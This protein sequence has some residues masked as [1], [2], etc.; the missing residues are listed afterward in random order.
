MKSVL[1]LSAC[2]QI[3][4]IILNFVFNFV[5]KRKVYVHVFNYISSIII[6]IILCCLLYLSLKNAYLKSALIVAICTLIVSICNTIYQNISVN[7]DTGVIVA[8]NLLT[9]MS[10]VAYFIM[11]S[12]YPRGSGYSDNSDNL[13]YSDYSGNSG[14]MSNSN[15]ISIIDNSTEMG[16]LNLDDFDEIT[17]TSRSR[18]RNNV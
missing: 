10:S 3:L 7:K 8:L 13:G 15:E 14:N 17:P 6:F 18:V 11:M 12:D 5:V 4:L 16:N 1:L 2:I 9:L